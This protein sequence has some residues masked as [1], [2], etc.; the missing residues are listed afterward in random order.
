M[1]IITCQCNHIILR[2]WTC[3][4]RLEIPVCHAY[5]LYVIGRSCTRLMF[6]LILIPVYYKLATSEICFV[7]FRQCI[8]MYIII[9]LYNH[10]IVHAIGMVLYIYIHITYN[11]ELYAMYVFPCIHYAYLLGTPYSY[12]SYPSHAVSTTNSMSI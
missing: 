7:V 5:I 11:S 10:G 6:Y 9:N 12:P 8:Y 2:H 1:H 4:Q 3:N